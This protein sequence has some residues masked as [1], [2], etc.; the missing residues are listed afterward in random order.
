MKIYIFDT[1]YLSWNKKQSNVI[2]NPRPK[3][4]FPELIQIFIKEIFTKKKI[5]KLIFAKPKHYEVYPYRISKLTG[6]KKNF[7]NKNGLDFKE[8]YKILTDFIPENSLLISN[9]D[10]YRILDSNI[11]INKI[12]KKN[13]SIYLLNFYEIIKDEKIFS[14]F[15]KLNYINTETIKKNLKLKIKS[16]NAMNDVNILYLC[17]KKIK[18]KKSSLVNYKKLFKL[19]KI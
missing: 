13:K 11:K 5:H 18:L 3:K 8:V 6:I 9:G 7:L 12:K 2:D 19:Y 4:Q 10:D 14:S 17:L 15:K 16:H 1:E